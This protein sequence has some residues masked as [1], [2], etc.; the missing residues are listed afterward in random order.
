MGTLSK[1]TIEIMVNHGYYSKMTMDPIAYHGYI[2]NIQNLQ[3]VIEEIETEL[4]L[5]PGEKV[6]LNGH[7]DSLKP[8]LEKLLI[9]KQN[10][11]P[12]VAG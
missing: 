6:I 9:D 4:F 3:D 10:N 12:S 2:E 8:R 7:L 5:L 1:L 11:M